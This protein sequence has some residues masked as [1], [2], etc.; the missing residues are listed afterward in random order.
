MKLELKTIKFYEKMSEETNCF[1]AKLYINGKYCADVKNDGKGGCTD[2][3]VVYSENQDK[4]MANKKAVADAEAYC[5][6]LPKEKIG[7]IEFQPDLESI[8]DGLFEE[9]LKAKGDMKFN[10]HME[11]GIL[12]GSKEAYQ[13]IFWKNITL[14]GM[15]Q[16]PT[17]LLRIKQIVK[18]LK[19]KGETILNTNLPD[20]VLN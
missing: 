9:F 7:S 10:K 11:Q 16:N 1:Q 15:L 8:V 12:Y 5:K 17:G 2:I 3:R 14:S 19:A 18:D 4:F 13:M 6:T 20:E